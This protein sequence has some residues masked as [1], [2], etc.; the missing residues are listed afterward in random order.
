M[1]TDPNR[2]S[3][4]RLN[5]IALMQESSLP[6][7]E[8]A[9]LL[10]IEIG[11]D[12]SI[13]PYLDKIN[14]LA[15]DFSRYRRSTPEITCAKAM[16]S[17]FY[18]ETGFAGNRSNYYDPA[19]SYLNKVID[20]RVGIPIS[21]AIL[22][23]S[24]GAEL[25]IPVEGIGFPG[26]FLVRYKEDG[27]SLIDPFFGR[28]LSTHD[29]KTLLQQISGGRLELDNTHL[30]VATKREILVRLI[31]NLKSIFWRKK[32]WKQCQ[33]C[34]ENQIMLS[35]KK[36]QFELQLAAIFEMRGDQLEAENKYKEIIADQDFNQDIRSLAIKRLLSFSQR[37]TVI[38]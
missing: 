21:L 9:L 23:M 13:Q 7:A 5:E 14:S 17:F 6:L 10:A 36:S 1:N 24:I 32:E 33:R 16:I 18:K 11:E 30:R 20:N 27:G 12:T 28:E 35:P 8:A 15:E 38:H 29:C 3:S 19:N 26:H 37:P 4:Q 34:I 31:D 25:D 2:F 22:Q